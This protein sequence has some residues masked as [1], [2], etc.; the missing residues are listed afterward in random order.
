MI[1]VV[2]LGAQF[3]VVKALANVER[4]LDRYPAL[5]DGRGS[6]DQLELL[7]V[8][9]GALHA[10]VM[11]A[12]GSAM[13]IDAIA[14]H[15]RTLKGRPGRLQHAAMRAAFP[16]ASE[17]EIVLAGLANWR[18]NLAR[19]DQALRDARPAGNA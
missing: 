19:R 11:K 4:I 5:I 9:T 3:D 6:D 18:R 1:G 15:Q 12:G 8:A 16:N 2:A 14:A 7:D 10:A 17:G 13:L